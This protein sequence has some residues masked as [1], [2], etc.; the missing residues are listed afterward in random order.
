VLG[1]AIPVVGI[2]TAIAMGRWHLLHGE[3]GAAAFLIVPFFD[4]A[5]FV[6]AFGLAIALRARPEYHRRLMLVATCGLAVAAFF[7]FPAAIIPD[8]WA[9]GAVDVLLL[10][11]VARDL[12]V[13]GRVHP[14]Y[15]V[16]IPVLAICQAATMYVYLSA[17]PPWLAV[18]GAI[19]GPPQ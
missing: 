5:A 2:A 15:L 12:A 11:G 13:T 3:H 17:W 14:V 16:G 8:N 1:A 9:Y 19:L 7:R 18:A 4:M 10:C 6:L